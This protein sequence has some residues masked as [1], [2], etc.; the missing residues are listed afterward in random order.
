MNQRFFPGKTLLA[1]QN[2][3]GRSEAVSQTE[4]HGVSERFRGEEVGCVELHTGEL[5]TEPCG[6]EGRKAL[7]LGAVVIP[8]T[9]EG[10]AGNPGEV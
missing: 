3:G 1:G 9:K 2:C 8:D 6:S 7:V 10:D 4:G 5:E